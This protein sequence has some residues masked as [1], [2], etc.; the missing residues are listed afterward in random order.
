MGKADLVMMGRGWRRKLRT[1]KLQTR[2]HLYDQQERTERLDQALLQLR[3]LRFLLSIEMSCRCGPSA[4]AI[5]KNALP[6]HKGKAAEVKV[7]PMNGQH[8]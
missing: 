7:G 8:H 2:L 5:H 1:G 4:F 6:A 3:F